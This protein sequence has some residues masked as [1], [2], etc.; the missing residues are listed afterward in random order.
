MT[1]LKM[2]N[3]PVN[4]NDLLSLVSALGKKVDSGELTYENIINY[5]EQIL[6]LEKAIEVAKNTPQAP[7]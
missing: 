7:Q 1:L 3:R 5:R 2:A 4:G 6:G